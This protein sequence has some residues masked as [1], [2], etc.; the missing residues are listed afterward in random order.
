MCS[1]HMVVD[2]VRGVCG[3]DGDACAEPQ[4]LPGLQLRQHIDPSD[5]RFTR[6]RVPS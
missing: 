6:F 3:D 2:L 1:A 4:Q 5:S